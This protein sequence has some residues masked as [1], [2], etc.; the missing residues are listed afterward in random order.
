MNKKDTTLNYLEAKVYKNAPVHE[1]MC[2]CEYTDQLVARE[3]IFG[4]SQ[5]LPEFTLEDSDSEEPPNTEIAYRYWLKDKTTL[6]QVMDNRFVFNRLAPY[7]GWNLLKPSIENV[8]GQIN[9]VSKTTAF[10]KMG[11]MYINRLVFPQEVVEISDYLNLFLATPNQM[12]NY[13]DF[14]ANI[15]IPLST[16]DSHVEVLRIQLN[17]VPSLDNTSNVN[18]MM[19]FEYQYQSTNDLLI[20]KFLELLETGH[21][22][23]SSHFE[24]CITNRT[25]ELFDLAMED[26]E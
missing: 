10:R 2:V 22:Q 4:I 18:M 20:N 11:L 8:F 3:N 13:A 14:R 5:A 25:R 15:A 24:M 7:P 19:T 21:H 26:G 9:R 12:Q 1:V 6:F 17:T 16:S 23:I